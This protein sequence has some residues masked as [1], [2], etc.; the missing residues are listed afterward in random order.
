MTKCIKMNPYILPVR[1]ANNSLKGLTLS[2]KSLNVHRSNA[3]D[4]NSTTNQNIAAVLLRVE[5]AL[6]LV[7]PQL[8]M[9]YII[10]EAGLLVISLEDD[11]CCCCCC[12]VDVGVD[13]LVLLVVV[14]AAANLDIALFDFAMTS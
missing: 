6:L 4:T 2:T 14:V 13:V 1:T 8:I 10:L 7:T 12:V 11:C 3:Y 9:L 5:L